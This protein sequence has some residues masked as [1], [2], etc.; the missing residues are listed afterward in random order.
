[1][2]D[3]TKIRE[4]SFGVYI[5]RHEPQTAV[6]KRYWQKDQSTKIQLKS[7]T[8]S[9]SEGGTGPERFSSNDSCSDFI[10]IRRKAKSTHGMLGPSA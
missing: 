9:G 1:M 10:G 5:I 7:E 3:L 2:E 6:Q 4:R 8:E